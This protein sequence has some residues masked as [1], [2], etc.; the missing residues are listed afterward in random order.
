MKSRVNIKSTE[1]GITEDISVTWLN[2]LLVLDKGYYSDNRYVDLSE[3][4]I[5]S[6]QKKKHPIT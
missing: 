1:L 4:Y 6:L 2:I 5:S 3:K